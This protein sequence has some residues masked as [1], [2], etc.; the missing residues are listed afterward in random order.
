M[1]KTTKA[2]T[3][4]CTI[5]NLEGSW[6]LVVDSVHIIFVGSKSARYFRKHYK[7]LGYRVE[8]ID[9]VDM[10]LEDFKFMLTRRDSYVKLCQSTRGNDFRNYY[11]DANLLDRYLKLC[12]N[13][14][15]KWEKFYYNIVH[16]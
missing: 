4:T 5:R 9:Y 16:D 8:Y 14:N 10:T 2:K 11:Y 15:P 6:E 12:L 7:R 13:Q 3:K 1:T